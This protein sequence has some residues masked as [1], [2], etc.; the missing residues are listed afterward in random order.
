MSYFL[1]EIKKITLKQLLLNALG[2]AILGAGLMEI[3]SV[4]HVTEGGALGLTLLLDIWFGFSPAWTSIILNVAFYA[5]GIKMFGI[6]FVAYSL[7]AA[8][9][10]SGAY[11]FC[12][13]FPPVWPQ[14]A[15]LPFL[16]AIIGAVFVGVGVGLCVKAGGAP[17]GD[18]AFAMSMAKITKID[19]QWM[20]MATDLLVL[21]L[22]LTC[23]PL[24]NVLCSL[25]TVILSGQ[26]I[27]VI[28]KMGKRKDT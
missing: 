25:V 24:K 4:A 17:S 5:F 19:I 18:D 20:Y 8:G 13:L 15:D 3:H 22:S 14:I 10:F 6:P 23:I 9:A 26:I 2:G 7:A 27:G 16:A 28:Q 12:E 1:T 21:A 11:A